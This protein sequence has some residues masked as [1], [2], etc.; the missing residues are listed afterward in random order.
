M[1]P[2]DCRSN[3]CRGLTRQTVGEAQDSA[4]YRCWQRGQG[5]SLRGGNNGWLRYAGSASRVVRSCRRTG[6]G[7]SGCDASAPSAV[8]IFRAKSR[9]RSFAG[10]ILLQQITH[11]AI[12]IIIIF[13]AAWKHCVR[14]SNGNAERSRSIR[15]EHRDAAERPQHC[16]CHGSYRIPGFGISWQYR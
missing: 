7:K 9:K 8:S 15:G 12:I 6:T 1:C 13:A 11:H 3:Q 16:S 2:L 5:E 10:W 14:D 4:P